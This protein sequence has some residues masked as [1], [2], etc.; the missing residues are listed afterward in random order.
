MD[1]LI[2]GGA[3]FIGTHLKMYIDSLQINGDTVYSYDIC[4]HAGNES[5]LTDVRNPIDLKISN[6]DAVIYNLAAIHTTPGHPDHSYFETNI[7]GA[8][9]I[10][11]F[12][13]D[14]HIQTIVFTS[15]IAPYGVSED[16][17]TEDSLP[18]PNTPYGISKLTAEYIH[19]IWQAE[20]PHIRRLIIV[21]PGVVF[22]KY[23]NGNFTRL[24]HAIKS[25]FFFYP[26]RRD[27]IKASIYVKDVA[28]ILYKASKKE[29][30]GIILLNLTYYPAP[31]IEEICEN[32]GDATGL[33]VPRFLIPARVLKHVAG[34]VYFGSTMFGKKING[35]H[36]ERVKKLMISTNISGLKLS[37]SEYRLQFTLKEAIADWFDDCEHK[38][39]F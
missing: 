38:D 31:T 14:N 5:I 33:S 1:H 17:K 29:S 37:Q 25:G 24:Y 15:S 11:N 32:I 20:E 9:N 30:P 22:G 4:S 10:C 23:E 28:R 16:L 39:L 13:R 18:M 36:P 8:E 26:G 27:T 7:Y 2:F 35:I 3:G 34:T 19:K 12:A 21:R 6:S